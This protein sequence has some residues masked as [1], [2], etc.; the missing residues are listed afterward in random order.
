M[1]L[2]IVFLKKILRYWCIYCTSLKCLLFSR[3]LP[4]IIICLIKQNVQLS[5][6]C[7]YYLSFLKNDD[8]LLLVIFHFVIIMVAENTLKWPVHRNDSIYCCWETLLKTYDIPYLS[9]N[10]LW[11][12]YKPRISCKFQYIENN[13]NKKT[14]S[15]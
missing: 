4:A 1:S 3:L 9:N 14:I 5:F 10:V 13:E 15:R 7:F 6:F 8:E 12:F 2:R 11:S